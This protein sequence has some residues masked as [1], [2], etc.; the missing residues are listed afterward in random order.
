MA[1]TFIGGL[2][3]RS[4]F[5]PDTDA[6]RAVPDTLLYRL[7]PDR[8]HP[9]VGE[10]VIR[11]GVLAPATAVEAAVLAGASGTVTSVLV[12]PEAVTVTV[13]VTG[14]GEVHRFPPP[15]T[16]LAELSADAIAAL[17][18][19]RGIALPPVTAERPKQL[20]VDTAGDDPAVDTRAFISLR[21]PDAVVGGARILMKYFGVRRCRFA[22]PDTAIPVARAIESRLPRGGQMLRVAVLP[23]K[24]PLSEPR[25]LISALCQLEIH[26]AIDPAAIGY[27]V[28]PATLC[29]AVY[30]ALVN[31]IPYTEAPLT[32][33]N[34]RDDEPSCVVVAPFGS[35]CEALFRAVGIT[36]AESDP[37]ACGG[38]YRRTVLNGTERTVPAMESLI[39]TAPVKRR[40][41]RLERCVG[42]GRCQE[43][44]PMH[45]VPSRLY[46]TRKVPPMFHRYAPENCIGC[47]CCTASCP[48][49]L[50]L[51]ETILTV[52]G[53]TP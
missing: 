41:R 19:E 22:V 24:Y 20:F 9:A 45:L 52:R 1:K 50:P 35:P 31:G 14:D 12:D 17:L 16:G 47:G 36:V 10:S 28:V 53:E 18:R 27:Y 8:P 30:E 48:A 29:A 38:S 33:L 40:F 6:V 2:R 43:V 49:G 26:P 5:L 15:D 51:A 25:L 21:D 7:A 42:C 3:C 4:R 32:L 44:C 46:E 11:G 13:T 34:E 39:L 37:L 23:D